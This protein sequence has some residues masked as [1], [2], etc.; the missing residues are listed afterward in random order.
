MSALDTQLSDW[1]QAY[2]SVVRWKIDLTQRLV[3]RMQS[4]GYGR[5][6]FIESVSV[7][8]PLVNLVLSN[9]M[10]LAVVGFVKTLSQEIATSGIT[11]N[12]MGPGLHD[13]PR[14]HSLI[15]KNAELSGVSEAEMKSQFAQ[16]AKVGSL[17]DP[18]DF[19][20]LALWLLS[21]HAR[22]TTGQTF[23]VDGGF[24]LGTM[25]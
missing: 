6:V 12:I 25:G 13:T 7:K 22:Y 24:V 15:K 9:A 3:K 19:A 18:H 11:L 21:P 5:L 2:Q 16:R 10:R 17:G 4:T 8:Q 14:L 23:S 20:T 1:D